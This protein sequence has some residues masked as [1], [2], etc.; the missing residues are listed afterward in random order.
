MR[1]MGQRCVSSI[2]GTFVNT[3]GLSSFKK[4]AATFD[5]PQALSTSE[6]ASLAVVSLSNVSAFIG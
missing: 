2:P 3:H 5:I 6:P 4:D 1:T